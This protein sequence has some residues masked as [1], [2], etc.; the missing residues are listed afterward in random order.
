VWDVV[1]TQ[2]GDHWWWNAWRASTSTELSGTAP[3]R[4][5][6]QRDVDAAIADANVTVSLGAHRQRRAS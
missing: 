2:C 6:A 4:D 1:I 5:E 3:S